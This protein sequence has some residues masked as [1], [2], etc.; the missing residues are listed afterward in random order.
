MITVGVD[1]HKRLHV[2][3][4]VDETGREIGTWKGPNTVL[5]WQAFSNWL[6][7]FDAP[8]QV[9]IEG[10]WNYGRGLAQYLVEQDVTVFEVNARWTAFGRRTSRKQGKSDRLDS[11]AVALFVVR[12]GDTLNPIARDD[13]TAVLNLLCREREDA[14]IESTKLRNQLHA[15]LMQLDPGYQAS[16]PNLKSKSGLAALLGFQPPDESPLSVHRADSL[17][18]LAHRLELVLQQIGDLEKQITSLTGPRFDPLLEL[19][20]VNRL[21]AATLAGILGPGRRFHSDAALAAFAG[22]AP[23]EASSAGT[24]RHRLN[25]TGDRRLNAVVY[26]IALT[27]AHYSPAARA[28]LARRM[29]E[30]KTKKEAMR[31]LKRYIVRAV[32]GA[33]INCFPAGS[34][35]STT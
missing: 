13:E 10:A 17:K 28:Y 32:W 34:A 2:G 3:T 22:V 31:A 27:Q 5:G 30:G 12:A 35:P 15:L 24:V 26:R 33:W 23:L 18:R 4:A 16:W 11:T 19:C 7:T 8:R 20:G 14:V 21:T 1:A 25:R 29:S 6:Q 9:G